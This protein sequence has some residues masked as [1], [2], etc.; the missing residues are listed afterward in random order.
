MYS[1]ATYR[2]QR[3]FSPTAGRCVTIKSMERFQFRP[4]DLLMLMALVAI[5]AYLTRDPSQVLLVAAVWVVVFVIVN[6]VRVY[7][8][9]VL[10][11]RP[12]DDRDRNDEH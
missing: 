2:C 7:A 11:E 8:Q 1:M 12:T 5:V 10:S 3:F 4:R 6:R 9:K